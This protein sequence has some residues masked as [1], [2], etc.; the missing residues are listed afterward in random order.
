M[1]LSCSSFPGFSTDYSQNSISYRASDH[2]RKRLTACIAAS[3]EL[4]EKERA[5]ACKRVRKALT[6]LDAD[7]AVGA[8]SE[9]AAL[10]KWL[11]GLAPARPKEDPVYAANLERFKKVLPPLI[12]ETCTRKCKGERH[13]F[14][15][16]RGCSRNEMQAV[17]GRVKSADSRSALLEYVRAL[18][19]HID[20]QGEVD[21]PALFNT[22]SEEELV[23]LTVL[24]LCLESATVGACKAKAHQEI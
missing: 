11:E 12:L 23:G 3:A 2:L 6:L 19:T 14:Q 22:L 5:L 7:D 4:K 10:Q 18:D 15:C 24:S 9:V 20:Y 21:S 13:A 17:I 16:L 8:A 1:E